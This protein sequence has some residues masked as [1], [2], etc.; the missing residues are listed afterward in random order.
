MPEQRR[1][2]ALAR[3]RERAALKEKLRTQTVLHHLGDDQRECP[4]CGRHRS[5]PPLG[6]GKVTHLYEYVPGYF[7]RQCHVQEKAACAC[8]QFI[9]TADPAV[10]PIEGGITALVSSRTHRGHEV[11]GLDSRCIG[12]P[13][14]TSVSAQMS[15]STLTDLFPQ[16]R[17]RSSRRYRN[18]FFSSSPRT[19]S[20]RR[21]RPRS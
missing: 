11:R 10:R 1:L 7:V 4:H 9:A 20:C 3:R 2:A 21:T 12:S 17:P 16:G 18:A 13:S 6:T 8:G 5:S 19:K 14:S 15:R